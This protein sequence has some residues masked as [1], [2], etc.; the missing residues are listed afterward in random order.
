MKRSSVSSKEASDCIRVIKHWL[1]VY[2]DRWGKKI[3]GE[4]Q[5]AYMA[6]LMKYHHD[7]LELAFQK[8]FEECEYF[9]GAKEIRDRIVV[10]PRGQGYAFIPPVGGE[11]QQ[12]S[13]EGQRLTDGREMKC[14]CRTCC[15]G[16]WRDIPETPAIASHPVPHVE[17]WEEF[18]QVVRA[19]A[20]RA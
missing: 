19:I 20:G 13:Y 16:Y 5:E 15:P 11:C 9:P 2:R 8:C 10:R 12:S 1:G 4:L 7:D 17:T 18:R 6:A 3:S 14:A